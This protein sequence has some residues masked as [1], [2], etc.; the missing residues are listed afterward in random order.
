[1][2]IQDLLA[3]FNTAKKSGNGWMTK[4]PGHKDKTASLHITEGSSGNILMKCFAGCSF[5]HICDSMG[6]D[7]KDMF[8]HTEQEYDTT[9]NTNV[10]R[11]IKRRKKRP[12]PVKPSANIL[13]QYEYIRLD[14][15]VA[16]R[17]VRYAPAIPKKFRQRGPNWENSVKGIRKIPFKLTELV[18]AVKEKQTIFICEGEKDVLNVIDLGLAATTN[19]G[20]AQNWQKS[21]SKYLKNANVVIL[22]DNDDAGRKRSVMICNML[23]GH[24]ASIK[25]VALPGLENKGDV[26]DWIENG[27]SKQLLLDIVNKTNEWKPV[28]EE[29]QNDNRT[30]IPIFIDQIK[31]MTR[32]LEKVL[33]NTGKIFSRAGMLT[34]ITYARDFEENSEH[35]SAIYSPKII[36]LQ[37]ISITS[38]AAEHCKFKHPEKFNYELPPTRVVSDLMSKGS[39]RHIKNVEGI[40]ESPTIKPN[41]DIVNGICFDE[42]LQYFVASRIKANVSDNP[43]RLDAK[44][45]V[46][47]VAKPLCDF[48]FNDDSSKYAA[49]AA[50]MSTVVRPIIHGPVPM[51]AIGA[52]TPGSGK[53]LLADVISTV[54]TGHKAP[55]VSSSGNNE[56]DIKVISSIALKGAPIVLIDN[57]DR[58]F[59]NQAWASTLTA[60]IIEGRL[61]GK[62]ENVHYEL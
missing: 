15:E 38:L 42:Q 5:Q 23:Q 31:P 24:A 54:A 16:M 47:L 26:S 7:P 17:S 19:A 53:T 45:A 28:V 29:M 35:Y 1:M 41:G 55:K 49:I 39:W 4:C 25:V 48:P 32:A 13:E 30:E 56:E 8:A 52:T 33:A 44:D 40:I 6:I 61:L 46:G 50:M 12:A 43:T 18:N 20:G 22:E 58:Q 3:K 59:G 34:H 9:E 37:H 21:F 51:V 27:G 60:G 2:D 36:P 62:N 10:T 14:G 57:I 11:K